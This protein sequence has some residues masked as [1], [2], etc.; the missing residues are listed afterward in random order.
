MTSGAAGSK[1]RWT[2]RRGMLAGAAGALGA[3]AAGTL[4]ISTPAQAANGDPVLQGT[5]NGPTTARTMIFATNNAELASLADPST[6]IGVAGEGVVAGVQGTGLG[7][8]TGVFGSGG[9]VNRGGSSGLPD[10]S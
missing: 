2:S 7:A 5:D 4:S 3:V 8:G 10:L 9:S 6:H 1:K